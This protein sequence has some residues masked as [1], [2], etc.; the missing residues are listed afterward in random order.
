MKQ[1]V[2]QLKVLFQIV[3]GKAQNGEGVE[4]FL[5]LVIC[6][7]V[8]GLV[9]VLPV[10]AKVEPVLPLLPCLVSATSLPGAVG[11]ALGGV[12]QHAPV[13]G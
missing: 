2:G 1:I 5:G 4:H 8:I 7:V 9:A 13:V 11:A 6:P 10:L 12:E 3:T